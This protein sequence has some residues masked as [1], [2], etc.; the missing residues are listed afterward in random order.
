MAAIFQAAAVFNQ[1]DVGTPP[2]AALTIIMPT[3]DTDG[4]PL[5]DGIMCGFSFGENVTLLSWTGAFRSTPPTSASAGQV[6]NFLYSINTNSWWN[7]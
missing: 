1:I 7:A 3:V 6:L 2:L 4:N 5:I